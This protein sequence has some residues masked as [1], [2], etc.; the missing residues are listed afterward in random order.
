MTLY[1]FLSSYSNGVS[2]LHHFGDYHFTALDPR[3]CL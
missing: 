3:D 1:Y 2:I